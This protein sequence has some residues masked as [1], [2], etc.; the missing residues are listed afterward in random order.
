MRVTK[1]VIANKKIAD[2]SILEL[3]ELI[4]ENVGF[5]KTYHEAAKPD[6]A[7]KLRYVM[8]NIDYFSSRV[9]D[10]LED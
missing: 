10:T 3:L 9:I 2:H 5:A 8:G 7:D 6:M 1:K 4:E